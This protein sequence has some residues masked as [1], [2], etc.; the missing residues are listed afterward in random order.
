MRVAL[1]GLVIA[2]SAC[3]TR[4][5]AYP[6]TLPE[7]TGAAPNMSVYGAFDVTMTPIAG[8]PAQFSLAKSYSGPLEGTA[9]GTMLTAVT[10][11]AGSAA[12]VAVETFD[13]T[14][15]GKRG[16]FQLVHRAIMDRGAQ[17]LSIAVL[18]DSGTGA[19]KA[20]TGD[21][22]IEIDDAGGHFYVFN[23]RLP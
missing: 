14:L 10:P 4:P 7:E 12:Y 18:P 11:V 19:L 8:H 2:L 13:G 6:Q 15:E 9:T 17:S 5:V 20:L 21:M 22:A 16:T 23:Y 3:V 1:A